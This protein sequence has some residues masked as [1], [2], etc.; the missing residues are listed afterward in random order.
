L[1]FPVRSILLLVCDEAKQRV[2]EDCPCQRPVSLP[3]AHRHTHAFPR[4]GSCWPYRCFY[5][6]GLLLASVNPFPVSQTFCIFPSSFS[7]PQPSVFRPA[8]ILPPVVVRESRLT[9]ANLTIRVMLGRRPRLLG[10]FPVCDERE[11]YHDSPFRAPV[12]DSGPTISVR[13]FRHVGLADEP[14]FF[15]PIRF[16]PGLGKCFSVSPLSRTLTQ[17]HLNL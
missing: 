13:V 3:L 1:R 5:H 10:V 14:L 17:G 8:G 6:H 12:N 2:P 15:F 16:G 9:I 4:H 7:L 11:S